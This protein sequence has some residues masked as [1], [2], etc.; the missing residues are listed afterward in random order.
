MA[1][2]RRRRVSLFAVVMSLILVSIAV[3]LAFRGW[4]F[5]RLSLDDRTL[6]PEYR[7]LRPSG[8]FGNGYGWVA[9]MLVVL[10]LSYLVRRRFGSARFGSM[11]TWLDVH[12]LRRRT[13]SGGTLRTVPRI[14]AGTV[15][16]R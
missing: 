3:G 14:V 8:L 6:H 7:V 9:A 13:A 15:L 12:V 11:K 2:P 5:Y 1:V 4:S 16:P 10:N